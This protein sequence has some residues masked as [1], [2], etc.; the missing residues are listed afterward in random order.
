M[1]DRNV[2]TY[3]VTGLDG[4]SGGWAIKVAGMSTSLPN[5][6]KFGVAPVTE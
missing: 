4:S 5:M 1:V 6:A 3:G 2:V